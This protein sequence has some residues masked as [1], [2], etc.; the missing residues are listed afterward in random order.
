MRLLPNAFIIEDNDG[1]ANDV[2]NRQ[3]FGEALSNILSRSNESLV[4]SVDGPWGEGKST[5][6][7][8]WQGFLK[9][10]KGIHSIYIDAFENDYLDDAFISIVGAVTSYAEKHYENKG[11]GVKFRKAAGKVGLQLLSWSAK[12]AVKAASLGAIKEADID[13]LSELKDELAGGA[14]DAIAKFIE[15]RIADQEKEKETVATFRRLLSELPSK[16]DVSTSS[17][18]V[19]IIDELDRCR[20]SYAVEVLEKIKHLF[21]V[22]NIAF[23]LVLNKL[24][25][26]EAIKCVYGANIDAHAYLQ[27]FINIETNLPKR[28]EYGGGDDLAM[29]SNHLMAQHELNSLTERNDILESI[30]PLARNLGLS[31]RQME[32][33]FTNLTIIYSTLSANN[34]RHAPAI[35]IIS[36]LKVIA[37][38]VYRSLCLK[39]ANYDDVLSA[40]SLSVI[41]D[42]QDQYR[43]T[44]ISDFLRFCLMSEEEFAQLGQNDPAQR[45][46]S[47][48][49][50]FNIERVNIIPYFCQSLQLIRFN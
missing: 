47:L 31:L 25:L 45:F 3:P 5:F 2:F 10:E 35:C 16:L 34:L 30:N 26:E 1:F 39:Q 33:V 18:L 20:P 28:A 4:I 9:E 24:Q 22:P 12:V 13:A 27:K 21:A 48:M 17:R 42:N 6:V 46:S 23:V 7:K 36:V 40:L 44:S 32:K 8:M 38:S 50:N 43:L 49:W 15:N 29:Y 19:I 11:D 41:K 37:P 14:S